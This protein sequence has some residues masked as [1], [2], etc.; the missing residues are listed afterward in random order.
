M[1][2]QNLKKQIENDVQNNKVVIYM[3]G[4]AD[5]PLCGFSARSIQILQSYHVPIK[6]YNV[7]ASEEL[8]QGIKEFT[9]W[10]TVPQIFIGGQFVG[11]CDIINEMHENGELAQ[12]LGKK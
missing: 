6:D 2:S 8:R 9:H 5:A 1:L 11:G 12:M 7:L 4:T 10:P 3:K